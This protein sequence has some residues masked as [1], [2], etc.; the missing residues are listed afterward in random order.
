METYH[1]LKELDW[2]HI[3][4]SYVVPIYINKP[5]SEKELTLFD[6]YS[7]YPDEIL[8]RILF[9]LVDDGSPLPYTLKDWPLNMIVLRVKEDIP[10]NNYGAKN[11]GVVFAKSDKVLITDLDHQVDPESFR[12]IIKMSPCG[13]TIWKMPRLDADGKKKRAHA[14]TF[15]LSRGQF[16]RNYGYDEIYCGNYACGDTM[17]VKYAKYH[18]CR[19]L[20][21]WNGAKIQLRPAQTEGMT[22][23][24]KR[25]MSHN[26]AILCQK[27]EEIRQYG[28]QVGHSRQFLNFEYELVRV[29]RRA[30]PL[31]EKKNPFWA[32]SWWGRW[33]CSE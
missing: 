20:I 28:A 31:P 1:S 9:V 12:K 8:D 25:D 5:G 26:H 17:L 7:R 14:D 11:L 4:L 15:V 24:L 13:R 2:S 32:F 33:V 30:V 18:G 29:T 6:D 21:M 23:S 22:H 10:W 3:R 27:T 19:I 16:M